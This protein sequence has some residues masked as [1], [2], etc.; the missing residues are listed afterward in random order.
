[1]RPPQKE[2]EERNE[3]IATVYGCELHVSNLD[4][5][6]EAGGAYDTCCLMIEKTPTVGPLVGMVFGNFVKTT[7]EFC[8][9]HIAPV[10]CFQK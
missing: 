2:R 10:G 7:G 8:V 4:G 6:M 9:F 5:W 1:M 3:R